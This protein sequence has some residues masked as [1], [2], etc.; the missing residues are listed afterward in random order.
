M[1]QW[2][3]YSCGPHDPAPVALEPER[4][5]VRRGAVDRHPEP[6]GE[7]GLDLGDVPGLDVGEPA[8]GHLPG[9][10]DQV[11]PVQQ[12][13]AHR[14]RGSCPGEALSGI[15]LNKLLASRGLGSRRACD[16]LIRSGAVRVN[17][18]VVREPGMRIEPGRDRV[19][20]AGKPLPGRSAGAYYMLHKPIGVI[21]T[22]SDPRG[23][24]TVVEMAKRS[25][26]VSKGT[27]LYPVGRLDADSSGL[28]LLTDDGEEAWN[29]MKNAVKVSLFKP[30]LLK[31]HNI[32][33]DS[34]FDFRKYFT[35]YAMNKPELMEQ[36]KRAAMKIPDSVART[37]IGVGKPDDAIQML[38]RFIKA[39]TNH[40]IIRFWGEGYFRSIEMFG[41]KVIPYFRDQER[42]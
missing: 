14:P 3:G 32:E 29:K 2:Q 39:G 33:Q 9:L 13:R 22:A 38:E 37:A 42:K 23:R 41:N 35:E 25:G 7:L 26:V 10:G 20:A 6:P 36:M 19:T 12:L 11:G 30:E 27:R 5:Q 31:V 17:G 18:A 28:L 15:R 16:A 34:E 8:A 1:T 21:S 24:T 40:F 4:P